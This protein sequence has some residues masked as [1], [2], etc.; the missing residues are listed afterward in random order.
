MC[1]GKSVCVG[2]S[3]IL[4]NVL[5]VRGLEC[6]LIQGN[7]H[8]FNQVKI[9]GKW[10]YTDLTSDLDNFL[11]GNELKDTLLSEDEFKYFEGKCLPMHSIP[12][13]QDLE[14]ATESYNRDELRKMQLMIHSEM[15]GKKEQ[16]SEDF[17]NEV[18]MERIAQGIS[19]RTIQNIMQNEQVKEPSSK[20]K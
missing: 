12:I 3:E 4:R 11:N 2:I 20:E 18:S 19:S 16:T 8:A 9:N 1:K 6:N 13:P 14:E 7:G 17:E 5:A 10:Y 15:I